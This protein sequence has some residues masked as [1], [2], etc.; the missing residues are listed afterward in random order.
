VPN[1]AVEAALYKRACGYDYEEL[2]YRREKTPDGYAE[3]LVRRMVKHMPPDPNSMQFWLA[4]RCPERWAY[5]PKDS[6]A[7]AGGGVVMMPEVKDEP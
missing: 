5:K 1:E 4:N 3:V 7:E 2:E 6:E